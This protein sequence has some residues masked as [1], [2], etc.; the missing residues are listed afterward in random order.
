MKRS[1]L[2]IKPGDYVRE[3]TTYLSL[4][5]HQLAELV[6]QGNKDRYRANKEIAIY[7]DIKEILIALEEYEI[8]PHKFPETLA[9]LLGKDKAAAAKQ[10]QLFK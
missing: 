2:K 6:Q 5:Q 9:E 7:R 4:R 8:D 1:E 3:I 10:R